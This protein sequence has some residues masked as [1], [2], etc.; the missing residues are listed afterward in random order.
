MVG[1]VL[2]ITFHLMILQSAVVAMVQLCTT[3]PGFST[4]V[5]RG[6]EF[7]SEIFVFQ[8]QMGSR[9]VAIIAREPF[10]SDSDLRRDFFPEL[11]ELFV[12]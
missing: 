6:Q 3:E 4:V 8:V 5:L 1:M 11:K 9:I 2:L 12:I 7:R 10:H